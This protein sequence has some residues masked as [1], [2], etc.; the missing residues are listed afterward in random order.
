MFKRRTNNF[1][2]FFLFIFISFL[3]SFS[4]FSKH[5]HPHLN[6]SLEHTSSYLY[7]HDAKCFSHQ[8]SCKFQNP[9][10]VFQTVFFKNSFNLKK[11]ELT[12]SSIEEFSFKTY[13]SYPL[14][15]KYT[16]KEL[17]LFSKQNSRAPPKNFLF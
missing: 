15:N 14:I 11:I 13:F 17:Y 3:A 5:S 12:S 4:L 6:K 1:I 10:E 2:S 8:P 9:L 16:Y 7:F